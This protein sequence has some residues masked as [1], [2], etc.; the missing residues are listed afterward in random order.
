[1]LKDKIREYKKKSEEGL[2]GVSPEYSHGFESALNL[3]E[4]FNNECFAAFKGGQDDN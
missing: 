1:M 2:I 3:I 4:N